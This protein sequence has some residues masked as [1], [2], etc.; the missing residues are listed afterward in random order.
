MKKGVIA[1]LMMFIVG[2]NGCSVVK[3]SNISDINESSRDE[4]VLFDIKSEKTD[5]VVYCEVGAN[6]NWGCPSVTKKTRVVII[7]EE[8]EI[9]KD[10]NLIE[11]VEDKKLD[12]I[13][14]DFNK[15]NLTNVARLKLISYLPI[16]SKSNVVLNGYTD[17]LGSN[18][19]NK[20]LSNNRAESVK[21]M[22]IE[23]GVHES[24]I[25]INGFGECC[26]IKPNFTDESRSINRRVE[27]YI[28]E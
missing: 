13:L 24:K 6:S 14:F 18:E 20:N 17:D 21:K 28:K 7:K 22:L 11:K 26:F 15:S 23:Y 3:R 8:A 19:Y 12:N 27:I 4:L 1:I 9:S 16:L 25:T 2:L 10:E 5:G